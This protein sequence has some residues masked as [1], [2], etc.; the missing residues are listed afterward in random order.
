[1]DKASIVLESLIASSPPLPIGYQRLSSYPL[2]VDK[3]INL[4]SSLVHPSLPKASYSQPILDQSLVKKS[5]DL[6]S[7]PVVHS[8]PEEHHD[9]TAH[10]LL[11]S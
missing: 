1:M 8:V 4:D 2:P 9:Y 11:V 6:D 10:V 7:P 3:E 5:V